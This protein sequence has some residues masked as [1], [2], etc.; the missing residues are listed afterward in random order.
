MNI[1]KPSFKRTKCDLTMHKERAMA[2]E[3]PKQKNKLKQKRAV[4]LLNGQH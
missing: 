2:E 4:S 3:K 1:Y